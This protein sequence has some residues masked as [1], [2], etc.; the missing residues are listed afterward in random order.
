ME[1]TTSTRRVSPAN[2][3][4]AF[5]RDAL[6]QSLAN[7]F[8]EQV[9]ANPSR[10]A[11]HTKTSS[12]TYAQLNQAANGIAYRLL[13]QN[14]DKDPEKPVALL[15]DHD[16]TL[17]SAIL[18]VWKAG[19]FYV[20]LDPS[21]PT[22]RVATL[23]EDSGAVLIATD[24]ANYARALELAAGKIDILNLADVEAVT[25]SVNPALSIPN[26]RI[27]ALIYTSGST[28]RPKGVMQTLRNVLHNAMVHTNAFHMSREDRVSLLASC[29][30]GAFLPDFCD[31]LLNGGALFPFRF[32]EE[33]PRSLARWLAR[34]RISCYNSVPAL[35]RSLVENLQPQDRFPDLR[36]ILLGGDRVVASDLEKYKRHF[37]DKCVVWTGLGTTETGNL[38]DFFADKE[39][40][41]EDG[42]VPVGYPVED[43]EIRILDENDKA[44]GFDEVGEIVVRSGFLSPGY[45]QR[46]DLTR[47]AFGP[48]P[49]GREAR[50]YRTGDLGLM[51]S[52]G[53]LVHAGRQDSQI[54]IR[55]HR[56][57]TAEIEITL[58][59]HQRVASA[60]V[61]P[62]EGNAGEPRLVAYIVFKDGGA[63]PDEMRRWVSS[64]LP[65]YMVPS[66]FVTLDVLPLTPNGKV[67][68][69]ALPE[70][71]RARPALDQ[72]FVSP[73]STLEVRL[74]GIWAEAF[75]LGQVGIHD[76]FFDLGG[77]SLLAAQIL[78]QIGEAFQIEVSLRVLFNAPTIAKLADHLEKEIGD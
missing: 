64:Q 40:V 32:R 53:C 36:L 71:S 46:P 58:W 69:R 62:W 60:V 27:A 48:D 56:I 54:K 2:P 8:E 28:G 7:R 31:A 41:I 12:L 18:A 22:T 73:K 76:N 43:K 63:P 9:A 30:S 16:A 13:K 3:F 10:L 11:L 4:V 65:D 19:E 70:P 50:V 14:A 24:R 34:E 67:D 1:K 68:R 44:V 15:L 42:Y 59:R 20:P 5:P 33:G 55:G 78:S 37:S 21:Q 17:I 51:R 57:E 6:E 23:L 47:Q 74:A 29:T 35:F 45:W 77:H 39:T 61:L 52:D 72:T 49:E 26:E 75:E 66:D 38:R 25:S